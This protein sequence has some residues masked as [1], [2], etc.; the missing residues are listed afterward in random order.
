M[1]SK[2]S[3]CNATWNTKLTPKVYSDLRSKT[4]NPKSEIRN[5][6]PMLLGTTNGKGYYLIQHSNLV[7]FLVRFFWFEEE[8]VYKMV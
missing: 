8:L 6:K 1:L 7:N 2:I 5:P 3:G 4:P